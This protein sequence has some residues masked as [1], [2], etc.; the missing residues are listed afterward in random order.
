MKALQALHDVSKR[1]SNG[2]HILECVLNFR[3]FVFLCLLDLI[4]LVLSALKWNI[5]I[6]FDT[7]RVMFKISILQSSIAIGGQLS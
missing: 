6:P 3:F 4:I 2:Y 7:N 1:S 5:L